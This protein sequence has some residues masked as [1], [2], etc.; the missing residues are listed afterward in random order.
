[1]EAVILHELAHIKRA[2]YLL[3]I[4]Q[5]FVE[6]IFFFNIFS[7]MLGDIIERERENACDDWVLQ[8]RYNSMHYAEALF[9][10]GRLKAIPAFA[11]S[12]SGK[13]ESLLLSRIK[14]LLH[15]PQNNNP[16]N[17]H[18]V[19]LGFFS[20]MIT[21][22]LVMSSSFKTK[23]NKE[24]ITVAINTATVNQHTKTE[25]SLNEK[26][27]PVIIAAVKH[28]H[29]KSPENNSSLPKSITEKKER[30]NADITA[31]EVD[32]AQKNMLLKKQNYLVQ[33]QQKLDSLH[34]A[35]PQYRQAINS[36][37]VVTPDV[38]QKVISYQNFKEIENMLAASG[39]SINVK[40][41]GSSKDSYQKQITIESTDKK[42]NKHTYTVVVELYQ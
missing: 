27:L 26:N 15:N 29:K 13:K 21:A 38:L 24:K 23:S 7:A 1:M 8:F 3:Y 4:L 25:T 20:V 31:R 34:F 12:F 6:R 17:F 9:K 40:E 39:D 28:E 11:M 10:L 41:T 5:N 30:L 14:R 42:G 2:D 36:E 22:C 33:V 16:Y 32:N 19:L 37:V 18:S 35:L